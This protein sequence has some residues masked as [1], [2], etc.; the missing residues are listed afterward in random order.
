[1]TRE[2][3]KV[4]DESLV[5]EFNCGNREALGQIYLRYKKQVDNHVGKYTSNQTEIDDLVAE[6]F[7]NFLIL[8]E[9]F[10]PKLGTVKNLLFSIS[11]NKI[12]DYLRKKYKA[13]SDINIEEFCKQ[14]NSTR[15]GNYIN[16]LSSEKELIKKEKFRVLKKA[17]RELEEKEQELIVLYFLDGNSL[18]EMTTLLNKN[19][20]TIKVGVHRAKNKL[21][22]KLKSYLENFYE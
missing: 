22:N 4:S 17:I 5:L 18:E 21:K 12:K 11:N 10:N 6:V 16:N 15:D 20:N 2:F 3:D 19:Y 8:A 14:E 7:K 9:K 13:K 1:M